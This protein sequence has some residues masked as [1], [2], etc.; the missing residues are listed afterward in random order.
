MQMF[1]IF[2]VGT[3]T[4]MCFSNFCCPPMIHRIHILMFATYGELVLQELFKGRAKGFDVEKALSAKSVRD[5]EKAISMVSYGF[6]AIEDFYSKSSTRSVVGNIK[7]PVLFIQVHI[8][9]FDV[10]LASDFAQN[11]SFF[12]VTTSSFFSILFLQ[13][14]SRQCSGNAL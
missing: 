7:I 6:E 2:I 13:K 9:C 12:S 11:L 8:L 4:F 3:E 14:E 10:N 5:F 1:H